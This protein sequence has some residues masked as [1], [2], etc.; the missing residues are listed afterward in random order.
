[1]RPKKLKKRRIAIKLI[2]VGLQRRTP[3]SPILRK[4]LIWILKQWYKKSVSCIT[5][6]KVPSH[7]P[8]QSPRTSAPRRPYPTSKRSSTMKAETSTP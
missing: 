7:P 2:T 3:I 6:R 4:L 8:N 5:K 1:M